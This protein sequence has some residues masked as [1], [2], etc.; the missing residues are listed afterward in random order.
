MSPS[1]AFDVSSNKTDCPALLDLL[2]KLG[3][4]SMSSTASDATSINDLPDT[5]LADIFELDYNKD[6]FPYTGGWRPE[7]QRSTTRAIAKVCR[8]WHQLCE[9]FIYR[10]VKVDLSGGRVHPARLRFVENPEESHRVTVA[11]LHGLFANLYR[12]PRLRALT[13]EVSIVSNSLYSDETA[14]EDVWQM[15]QLLRWWRP[16]LQTVTLHG[17]SVD[18]K[19]CRPLFFQISK[20]PLSHLTL[21]DISLSFFL[22]YFQYPGLR[23]LQLG[24]MTWT[25]DRDQ[26][27]MGS[28]PV[29]GNRLYGWHDEVHLPRECRFTSA[30]ECITIHLPNHHPGAL[31]PLFRWPAALKTVQI[32]SLMRSSYAKHWTPEAIQSLLVLQENSLR[33]ITLGIMPR[34]D[35]NMLDLLSFTQLEDLTLNAANVF[36]VDALNAV[37]RLAAPKL[38]CLSIDFSTEDQ[39]DTSFDEITSERRRWLLDLAQSASARGINLQQIHLDFRPEEPYAADPDDPENEWPWRKLKR[40]AKKMSRRYKMQLTWPTPVLNEDEWYE[41]L[42]ETYEEYRAY[43]REKHSER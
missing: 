4:A 10:R 32:T 37:D 22:K 18:D 26:M 25:A 28:K 41:N 42:Q 43:K 21:S 14:S 1:R 34:R 40:L 33:S 38:R 20:L 13:R 30:I 16:Q 3:F 15:I 6:I 17:S 23:T 19:E 36:G 2:S 8:R 39:H 5:L 29:M 31:N 27:S 35:V 11:T 24:Y 7:H 12:F 9:P